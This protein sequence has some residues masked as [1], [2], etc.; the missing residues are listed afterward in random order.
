MPVGCNLVALVGGTAP[1]AP[2]R[3]G[4]MSWADIAVLAGDL[5]GAVERTRGE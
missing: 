4:S 5:E 2:P 3:P 1:S